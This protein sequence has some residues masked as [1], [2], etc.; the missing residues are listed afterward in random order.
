LICYY[1]CA[2]LRSLNL[3]QNFNIISPFLIEE[4]F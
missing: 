2:V 4:V 1:I 3:S